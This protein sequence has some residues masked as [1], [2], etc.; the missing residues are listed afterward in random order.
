MLAHR[1]SYALFHE[2][3]ITPDVKLL[4]SCDNPGCVHPL[5][6]SEGTQ[7]DNVRDM[8]SKGRHVGTSKLTDDQVREIRLDPRPAQT[9]ERDLGLAAG[10]VSRIK[11]F[12]R[13]VRVTD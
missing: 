12:K 9:I 10:T 5:H 2:A 3:S 6:V 13:Y 4:H 11:N 1:V 8:V 7:G